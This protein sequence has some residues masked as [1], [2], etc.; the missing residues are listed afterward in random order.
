MKLLLGGLR[1]LEFYYWIKETIS[2]TMIHIKKILTGVMQPYDHLFS[3]PENPLH[4]CRNI[5]NLNENCYF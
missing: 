2:F 4:L 5:N 1:G 3:I